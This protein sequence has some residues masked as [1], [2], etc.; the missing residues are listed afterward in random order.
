MSLCFTRR[1]H[2]TELSVPHN[3]EILHQL[4]YYLRFNDSV[5]RVVICEFDLGM[6]LV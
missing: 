6:L 4:I 1:G 5:P 3:G 2:G